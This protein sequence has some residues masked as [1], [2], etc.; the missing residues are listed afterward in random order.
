MQCYAARR[1]AQVV[2][3]L[4]FLTDQAN[5][6]ER[7]RK[8]LADLAQKTENEWR[9]GNPKAGPPEKHLFLKK[10]KGV[11]RVRKYRLVPVVSFTPT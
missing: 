10:W 6:N 5:V 8:K 3:G 11:E 4:T 1:S 7:R 2:K 9:A